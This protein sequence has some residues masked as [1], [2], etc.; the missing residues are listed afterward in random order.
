MASQRMLTLTLRG[1]ERDGLVTRTSSDNP[2]TGGLRADEL[3]QSLRA[4]RALENGVR[5]RDEI[6]APGAHVRLAGGWTLTAEAL[7]DG[8]PFHKLGEREGL[9]WMCGVDVDRGQGGGG[10]R[11]PPSARGALRSPHARPPQATARPWRISRL[12]PAHVEAWPA[13][14]T[15][16]LWSWQGRRPSCGSAAP[17]SRARAGAR[18]TSL[19]SVRSASRSPRSASSS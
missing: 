8:Q 9:P 19:R 2:T 17:T 7:R 4:H 11:S 15:V 10:W 1:L 6:D 12:C 14:S 16:A 18:I 13:G 5:H 3:G